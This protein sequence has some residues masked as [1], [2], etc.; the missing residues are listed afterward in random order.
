[1]LRQ[2]PPDIRFTHWVM[3]IFGNI[4]HNVFSLCSLCSL[5]L[6]QLLFLGSTNCGSQER[7]PSRH[8][9]SLASIRGCDFFLGVLGCRSRECS[10]SRNIRGCFAR[11]REHKTQGHRMAS[12][13]LSPPFTHWKK[14]SISGRLFDLRSRLFRREDDLENPLA[15]VAEGRPIE[16]VSGALVETTRLTG[17]GGCSR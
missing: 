16:Q 13:G 4:I 9:R 15:A 3:G 17:D 14:R 6:I 5:W 1:V 8:S 11:R 12:L 2:N 7:S 10:P